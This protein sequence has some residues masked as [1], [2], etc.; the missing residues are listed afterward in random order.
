MLTAAAHESLFGPPSELIHIGTFVRSALQLHSTTLH[1]AFA[2]EI[3]DSLID[4]NFDSDEQRSTIEAECSVADIASSLTGILNDPRLYAH[5]RLIHDTSVNDIHEGAD[6]NAP[7]KRKRK[8]EVIPSPSEDVAELSAFKEKLEGLRLES[9]PLPQDAAVYLRGPKNSDVNT[10]VEIKKTA[11]SAEAPAQS[12]LITVTVHNRV[13][14]SHNFVSRCSQHAVL[15]TQTLGDL[16]E[17]IPCPSNETPREMTE[18]DKFVGY[19]ANSGGILPPSAGYVLVIEGVAY[20]DG[21]NEV[22][23]ADKLIA[24][25]RSPPKKGT[26]MHETTFSSL[27]VRLNEPYWLLHQGNCE[28]FLIID[29]IRLLHPEDPQAGYPLTLQITPPL[30]DTCRACSKVPAVYSIIGDVR[31]GESPCILC[32]PCWKAMGTPKG[33]DADEVMVIPLPLHEFGW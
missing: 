23:Y 7:N 18:N 29:Q 9:W 1:D 2:L 13:A 3:D 24:Y 33:K 30:L 28:H 8:R 4:L 17:I 14:W 31:L 26:K 21:L 15:S 12:A 19:E 32:A 5:A 20:G 27:S 25:M 10:L 11:D 16:F 22:D 6:R